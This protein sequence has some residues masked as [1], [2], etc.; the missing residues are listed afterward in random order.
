[1][2]Q[3]IG[4]AV[5]IALCTALG[6]SDKGAKGHPL[7]GEVKYDGQSIAY[8][9]VLFTPDASKQ[10]SGPQGIA[11][12]RNGQYDTG[13]DG[14]KG[15]AGGPTIIRVTGFRQE[16]GKELICEVEM[17]VELPAEGGTFNID[18]PKQENGVPKAPSPD[19]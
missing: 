18:V 5:L 17:Q 1:M 10:N 19:I 7:S 4:A 14:G 15:I 16:G 13:I 3:S 12:I 2:R 6:C 8:G 9:E 11:Y